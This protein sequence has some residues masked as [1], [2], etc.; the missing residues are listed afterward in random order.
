VEW[1]D[2]RAD[3]FGL[4]AILC[5]ILTGRPPF[6]GSMRE[7]IRQKSARAD[8]A[9]ALGR[10]ESCGA[11]AE[12]IALAKDCLAADRERRPRQAGEV[13][14]R[15]SAYQAGVQER[16]RAAELARIE[17]QAKAVEERKRRRLT[18]ALAASV[19]VIAGLV[20]GGWSYLEWQ[21]HD[22]MARLDRA[23]G[24][25]EGA[26]AE[27]RRIGDD[28]GRWL[29][30]RY[31]A[32]AVEGLIGFAPD[33][34]AR[35]RIWERIREVTEAADAA[36]NDQRLLPRLIDI[37]SAKADDPDGSINGS[38]YADAF[39]EGRLDMALAPAE[40]GAKIQTRP[41]AVRALLVAA[42]DRL[43]AKTRGGTKP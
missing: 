9:D 28:M 11:E 3:V 6:A 41:T 13:A 18:V 38:S 30:A 34:P 23:L 25:L 20:G 43:L 32:H 1:I 37:L 8:L 21:Q 35:R 7:E 27:A 39:R 19:L 29:F 33:A 42:V 36:A 2:E 31:A 40:V 17:A 14:R 10:L 22:R 15:I 24:E 16:L 4:G 5:E 12:L 26:Y